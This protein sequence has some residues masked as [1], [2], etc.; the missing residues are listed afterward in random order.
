MIQIDPVRLKRDENDLLALDPKL[1]LRLS[2]NREI[3]DFAQR[4]LALHLGQHFLH[5]QS[6]AES[7]PQVDFRDSVDPRGR[8]RRSL[9]RL[10][11]VVQ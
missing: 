10:H 7:R 1:P 11:Y 6:A 2:E 5:L 3:P 8:W 9:F 4:N